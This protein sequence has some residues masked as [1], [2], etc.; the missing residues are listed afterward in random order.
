V[1]TG[2]SPLPS[3]DLEQLAATTTTTTTTTTMQLADAPS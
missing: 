1:A 2:V 3:P